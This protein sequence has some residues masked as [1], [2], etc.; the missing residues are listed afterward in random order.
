V[1]RAAKSRGARRA[2]REVGELLT[3]YLGSVKWKWIF[4]TAL[5]GAL[6]WWSGVFAWDMG[7]FSSS[8]ERI[9]E[10]QNV[11][12]VTPPAGLT[13][14]PTSDYA[15]R[16]SSGELQLDKIPAAGKPIDATVTMGQSG[17]VLALDVRDPFFPEFKSRS[18]SLDARAYCAEEAGAACDS[19]SVVLTPARQPLTDAIFE[20]SVGVNSGLRRFGDPQLHVG[21]DVLRVWGFRFGGG[22]NVGADTAGLRASPMV[23]VGA[24]VKRNVQLYCGK[25]VRAGGVRCGAD[26]TF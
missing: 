15:W 8:P 12:T 20:P 5:I 21:A 24:Q 23:D 19:V 4:L 10:G 14:Q 11:T 3:T 26:L 13:P 1:K 6:L 18:A 2:L 17:K 22:L 9:E 16:D 7:V 25:E